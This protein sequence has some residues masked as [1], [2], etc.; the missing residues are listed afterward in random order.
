MFGPPGF[1]YVYFIYGMHW[2]CNV[3]C[4]PAGE[5]SAVLLRAGG[6]VA[7]VDVARARRPAARTRPRARPRPGPAGHRARHRPAPPTAPTCSTRRP[8]SGC[9]PATRCR[10]RGARRPAGRGRRR[11]RRAVAVLGRRRPDRQR[12]PAGQ[13]AAPADPRP[14]TGGAGTADFRPWPR[15]PPTPATRC[16][17]TCGRRTTGSRYGAAEVLPADG[18]AERLL[19]ADRE[20]RPLRVKLGIDPSGVQPHARPRGGA[21]QAAPVPGPR[22]HRGADRR[23]L[24]RPG[25][26]PLRPHQHPRRADRRADRAPTPRAT[27]SS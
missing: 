15:R 12:V 5:A 25:R 26:R 24:H 27:S 8:R 19:A 2:C 20:G 22:P 21:A 1:L 16:R 11:R 4:G 14:A 13:P 17:R 23:R 3:V 10:R 6:V 18:L 9:G 7:G